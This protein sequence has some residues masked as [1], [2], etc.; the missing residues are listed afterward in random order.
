MKPCHKVCIFLFPLLI[1]NS[2]SLAENEKSLEDIY[3]TGKVKFVREL[4]IKDDSFLRM[5]PCLK[6]S[7]FKIPG[8]L[9]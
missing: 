1:L 6:K 5:T 4:T 3:R 7:I 8:M 2:F 9:S